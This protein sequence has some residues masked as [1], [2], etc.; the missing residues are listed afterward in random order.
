[1]VNVDEYGR[2]DIY[3]ILMQRPPSIPL[4]DNTHEF[5]GEG[6]LALSVYLL[7]GFGKCYVGMCQDESRGGAMLEGWRL[8]FLFCC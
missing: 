3:C 2:Y 7:A 8:S 5:C 1:M 6:G 4:G